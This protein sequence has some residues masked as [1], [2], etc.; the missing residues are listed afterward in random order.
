MKEATR[1]GVTLKTIGDEK[2]AVNN[3]EEKLSWSE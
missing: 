2:E 3:G 1:M